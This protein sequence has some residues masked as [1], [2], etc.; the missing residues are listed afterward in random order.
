VLTLSAF[1]SL[2]A[3]NAKVTVTNYVGV[4]VSV[5]LVPVPTNASLANAVFAAFMPAAGFSTYFLQ[6]S[7]QDPEMAETKAT[8]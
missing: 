1:S 5:D 8:V 2:S 7:A 4:S 3:Q 6:F